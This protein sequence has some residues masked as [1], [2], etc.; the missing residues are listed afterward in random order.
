MGS[1]FDRLQDEIEARETQEGISP[2]DLLDLPPALASVIKQI[3]RR[4][5]M[6]LTEI[7]EALDQSPKDVK[8]TLDELVAKGYVRQIEVKKEIWYKAQFARKRS[9]LGSDVCSG[10]R[11]RSR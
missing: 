1:L 9:R 6:K 11:R 10:W 4:N 8:Q 5:G 3:I 2:A 7:A